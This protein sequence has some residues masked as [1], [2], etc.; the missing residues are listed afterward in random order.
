MASLREAIGRRTSPPV[1]PVDWDD[2]QDKPAYPNISD[3]NI[4]RDAIISSVPVMLILKFSS[5]F[6]TETPDQLRRHQIAC[7]VYSEHL[8]YRCHTS[9]RLTIHQ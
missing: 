6:V 7:K 5:G 2:E 1:P 3:T 8:Q 9:L 4:W